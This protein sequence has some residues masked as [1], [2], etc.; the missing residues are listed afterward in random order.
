MEEIIDGI[1]PTL[2]SL[3]GTVNAELFR[4][5][6]KREKTPRRRIA[7]EHQNEMKKFIEIMGY[8]YGLIGDDRTGAHAPHFHSAD[9]A[10]GQMGDAGVGTDKSPDSRRGKSLYPVRG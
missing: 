9:D 10:L 5:N 3:I 6:S 8:H 7:S 1:R 4:A 2:G